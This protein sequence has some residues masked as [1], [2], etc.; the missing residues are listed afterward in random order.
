[1]NFNGSHPIVY[2]NKYVVLTDHDGLKVFDA[3][4][5]KMLW[6]TPVSIA[7]SQVPIVANDKIYLATLEGKFMTYDIKTGADK[8][9]KKHTGVIDAQPV[10]NKGFLYIVS[11][12]ILTVIRSVHEFPW[13]QW[14]K[15]SRHNLNLD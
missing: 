11:A 5:E 10:Y 12:G 3:E 2:K 7:T 15:D 4:T 1:M 8:S 13:T 6:E 9:L 14:N